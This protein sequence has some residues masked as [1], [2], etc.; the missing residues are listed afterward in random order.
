MD[1]INDNI[2][3][4][5]FGHDHKPNYDSTSKQI[6]FAHKIMNALY[7]VKEV[8]IPALSS[9]LVNTKFKGLVCENAQ[10]ISKDHAPQNPTI[11]GMLAW[12]KLD[13]YKNCK[14]VIDNCALHDLVLAGK[15]V[16]HVLK[17]ESAQCVPLDDNTVSLIISNSEQKFPKFQKKKFSRHKIEQKANQNVTNEF[18]QGFID[19]LYRHQAAISINKMDLGPA[20]NFSHQIHLK[21]NNLVY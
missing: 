4:I 12:V 3:G 9:V 6:T 14:M 13:K 17:F 20:K 2:F 7:S 16:L 11:S 15:E 19:I 18:K 10:P 1:D 5:N 8:T 21:Q